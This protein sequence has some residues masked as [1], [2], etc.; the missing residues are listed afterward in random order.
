MRNEPGGGILSRLK[1]TLPMGVTLLGGI[2]SI[3][4]MEDPCFN[5]LAYVH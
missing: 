1:H 4:S 3:S 2:E 5:H